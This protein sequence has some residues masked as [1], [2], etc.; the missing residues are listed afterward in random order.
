MWQG[1]AGP[2]AA[3]RLH[4]GETADAARFRDFYKSLKTA[5]NGRMA[6]HGI[7]TITKAARRFELAIQKILLPVTCAR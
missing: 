2:S 7:V 5:I 4:T 6:R 3:H 1:V